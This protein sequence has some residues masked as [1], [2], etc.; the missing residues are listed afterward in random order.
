M[1]VTPPPPAGATGAVGGD[2]P[3]PRLGADRILFDTVIDG[4]SGGTGKVFDWSRIEGRPELDAAVL[5]GGL[6]PA[7]YVYGLGCAAAP[8]QSG[9]SGALPWLGAMLSLLLLTAMRRRRAS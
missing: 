9:A 6:N 7:K 5:A 1:A 3:E 4:R 8:M 2:V